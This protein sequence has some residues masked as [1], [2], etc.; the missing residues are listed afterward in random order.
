MIRGE[1]EA[2]IQP[3]AFEIS[4]R[5]GFDRSDEE[6]LDPLLRASFDDVGTE[7]GFQRLR[8][9]ISLAGGAFICTHISVAHYL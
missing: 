4:T 2:R 8:V 6:M 5:E 3:T 7:L 9:L 1:A